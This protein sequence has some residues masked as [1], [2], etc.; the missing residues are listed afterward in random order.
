M[1]WFRRALPTRY[2]VV[3]EDSDGFQFFNWGYLRKAEAQDLANEWMI[4]F[5]RSYWVVDTAEKDV[6]VAAKKNRILERELGIR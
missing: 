6:L 3:H 4:R 1:G 2:W 5:G